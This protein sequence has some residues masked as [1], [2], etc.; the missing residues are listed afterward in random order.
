MSIA[1]VDQPGLPTALSLEVSEL[2]ARRPPIAA[3]SSHSRRCALGPGLV[4]I[5]ALA[6]F[7]RGRHPSVAA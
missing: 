2:A 6:P 1:A 7:L 5:L 3:E 4:A